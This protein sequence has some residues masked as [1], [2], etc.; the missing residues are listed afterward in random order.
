[1]KK[2]IAMTILTATIASTIPEARAESSTEENVGFLS[3]AVTG[4]AVGGPIGFFVG[5]IVGVL[6]GEQVE[7]ANK[8]DQTEQVLIQKEAE[9][10]AV[11]SE[12]AFVKEQVDKAQDEIKTTN[13]WITEGLKLDLMFTTNSIELSPKDEEIINRLVSLLVQFPEIRIK[14]D[15]YADPRG[16]EQTNLELSLARAEAVKTAVTEQGI[17]S[18]RLLIQAHGEQEST[19]DVSDPDSYAF[20]RRV[21]VNFLIEQPS[22]LAQN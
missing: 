6:V 3:G 16:L 7:K 10:N 13:Q 2:A 20:D 1:M 11:E 22:T 19:N 15:G 14:L 9:F 18:S 21:S 4:A 12:L 8:L 17:D 5:G